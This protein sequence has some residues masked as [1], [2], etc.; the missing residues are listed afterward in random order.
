[1]KVIVATAG[2]GKSTFCKEN[3]KCIDFDSEIITD[4][5]KGWEKE[6]V[7]EAL[8]EMIKAEN[9]NIDI[10]FMSYNP[11]VIKLLKQCHIDFDVVMPKRNEV[12]KQMMI[13]R[14]LLRENAFEHLKWIK[15]QMKNWEINTDLEY[16]EEYAKHIY[17]ITPQKPYISDVL[18][19]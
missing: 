5:K 13:G 9:E 12:T 8:F 10:F 11:S 18:E 19:A 2:L 17:L 1:M 16:A 4:K 6:Y 14:F 7:K 15:R 3:E